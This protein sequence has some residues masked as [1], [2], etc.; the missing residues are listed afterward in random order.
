MTVHKIILI[1][2]TN[3]EDTD[4]YIVVPK[5]GATS[6]FNIIII[7]ILFVHISWKNWHRTIKFGQNIYT[8]ITKRKD[9]YFCL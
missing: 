7:I 2:K 3:I 1:L 4:F 6:C 9:L 5:I 8:N